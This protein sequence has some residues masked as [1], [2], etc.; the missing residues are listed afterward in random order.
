M[1]DLFLNLITLS[2][3]RTHMLEFCDEARDVEPRD[4][5]MRKLQTSSD[6]RKR[7]GKSYL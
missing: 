6:R 7:D 5:D 2:N 4:T 3:S 1:R